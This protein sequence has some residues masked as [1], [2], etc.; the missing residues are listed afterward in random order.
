MSTASAPSI[1]SLK[2][3]KGQTEFRA[4]IKQA[5]KVSRTAT[6]AGLGQSNS[7]LCRKTRIRYHK[8]LNI[9]QGFWVYRTIAA[10]ECSF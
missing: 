7:Q 8:A 1:P 5:G 4:I 9:R 6:A 10:T 3:K 2:G